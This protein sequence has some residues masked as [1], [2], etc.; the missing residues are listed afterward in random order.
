MTFRK[1]NTSKISSSCIK[2]QI[3]G[4]NTD[5][6]L[7]KERER[8]M[9]NNDKNI[10]NGNAKV[11]SKEEL[12]NRMT[13]AIL[14]LLLVAVLTVTVI[15]IVATVNNRAEEPAGDENGDQTDA[16]GEGNGSNDNSGNNDSENNG[17]ASDA[18]GGN[19]NQGDDLPDAGDGDSSGN[20]K[21]VFA[22]P[23]S[24][25][26]MK[27]F[28]EDTLVFSSTMNDYRTH[29]G[30]DIVGN[31]G[32]HVYAFCEGTVTSVEYDPFMG[33]TVTISHANGIESKYMNLS[34]ELAEQIK[35]GAT[36]ELGDVI[37]TIGET[38]SRECADSPHLHF[39]VYVNSQAVDP[40]NYV[41]FNTDVSASTDYEDR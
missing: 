28:C 16:E 29:S 19:I 8:I 9:N 13:Y 4:N 26:V 15:A 34:T 25:Y 18:M 36:V 21:Q 40:G 30:I 1:K 31:L 23:C 39:E 32:D 33:Q 12:A 2:F 3:H 6:S 35:V 11:K 38:A 10:T 14:A 5:T 22:L 7:K 37:G 20:S 27:D 24:G 41:T 17:D